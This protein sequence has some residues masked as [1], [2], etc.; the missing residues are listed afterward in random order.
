MKAF[1]GLDR[2]EKAIA[3][4]GDMGCPQTAKQDRDRIDKQF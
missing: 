4:L 3:I 2:N 1:D